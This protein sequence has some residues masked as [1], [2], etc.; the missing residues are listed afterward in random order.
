MAVGQSSTYQGT[1]VN[2]LGQIN[3]T[4]CQ[5]M[6]G[7]PVYAGGLGYGIVASGGGNS[8]NS[9][10]NSWIWPNTNATCRRNMFYQGLGQIMSDLNLTLMAP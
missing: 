6:S 9:T 7:G 2:N 1:T 5:G 3:V 10:W 4:V 8:F